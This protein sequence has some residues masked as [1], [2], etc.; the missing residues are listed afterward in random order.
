MKIGIV[1]TGEFRTL[2][3]CWPKISELF[4]GHS[5]E[6]VIVSTE[7]RKANDFWEVAGPHRLVITPRHA[8]KMGHKT[9]WWHKH[10]FSGIEQMWQNHDIADFIEA[11]QCD[12]MCRLRPDLHIMSDIEPMES[13]RH[14]VYVPKF[15]NW[16]GVNNQFMIG[17]PWIV[18]RYFR[19]HVRLFDYRGEPGDE[20]YLKW[21]FEQ[22][23]ICVKRTDLVFSLLR[24]NGSTD[25]PRY[26]SGGDIAPN[27]TIAAE[28]DPR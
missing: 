25:G 2:R 6:L 28:D 27:G 13:F 15:S 1:M 26:D 20:K 8:V 24:E 10:H 12:V 16:G 23:G 4:K 11:M 14:G 17:S 9:G 5:T 7:P 18:K 3:Q 21:F 19:R 22:E